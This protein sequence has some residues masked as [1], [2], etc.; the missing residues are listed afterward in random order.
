METRYHEEILN[1]AL[2]D[3]FSA[4]ALEKIRE[5]N[6]GQDALRGQI[7]HDEYHFDNNA[8]EAGNAYIEANRAEIPRALEENRPED[9]WKAFGRL[10][11]AAQDFYAH[12]NY[13]SLWLARFGND[14]PPPSEIEPLDEAL[15]HSPE[16][17]SGKL[18][19]PLEALTYV[20]FLRRFVLPFLP[21]D[22][23]A[24][25]NLDTPERG[26][27]FFYA[28][29][30]AVKRTREELARTLRLLSPEAQRMF[31]DREKI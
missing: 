12:S 26:E 29:E 23:H 25:M 24:W 4:R 28:M 5:G 17:H 6:I 30:A 7:G 11:H 21:R 16:L 9:A 3:V 10:T 22:S 31:L 19:Y 8:F 15:L 13:V 14:A 27:A 2:R 20:P 18:Y 1:K